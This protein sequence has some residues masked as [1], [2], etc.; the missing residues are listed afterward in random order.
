MP[1][2]R[3]T[4]YKKEYNQLAFNYCLLG[5][6]DEELA[7]FFD[8]SETTINNWKLQY[9]GFL[10]SLKRGKDQADAEVAQKLFH[11]AKGYSHEAV[12]IFADVKGGGEMIVPYVEHYP[13][14]TTAAI[15]WLKNRQKNKWRDASEKNV[16][17][18]LTFEG[19]Y[20]SISGRTD[21]LPENDPIIE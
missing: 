11:R 5:A 18:K 16:T 14:D 13:P 4:E 3:P 2:G 8:V 19:I 1:G 15:F 20:E 9:P 12:K 10:E 7:S 6:D 21:G 17:G